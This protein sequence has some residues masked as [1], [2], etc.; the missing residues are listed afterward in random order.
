[1]DFKLGLDQSLKLGLSM[2]M[3][4]SIEILKMG[5]KELKE[6]LENES[7]KNSNIEIIFPKPSFSKNEDYENYIENVGEEDES[8][9]DYL[10]EQI[11]YLEIKKELRDILEY[12]VNNLDE[13]GYLVSNLNELRKNS[14][15]KLNLFKEAVDILYTL[16]PIG[17]GAIDL[18]DCLK[19]QLE[20]KG[21]LTRTLSN[22]L[23]KNLEDIANGDLEKIAL[24]RD[25]PLIKVKECIDTIRNLNP[26]PARG[27][28]VNKK[29]DYIV[30]DLVVEIVGEEITIN[31]NESQI[32]KI[33]LKSEN[34]RDQTF[35]LALERGIIKRQETLLEVGRYVLNHQ[36]DYLLFSKN[37]KTLKIKDVA[38]GL[39]LHEST[40]SR[41]LKDKFIRI[42]GKIEGLK[43]YIVL[44][45]KTELI[46]E[47][48][49]KIIENEDKKNPLS[50]EKILEKLAEKNLLV[51]RRT[52]GKYREELGI[53]SSRKRKK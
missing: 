17:V 42:D 12:L 14:G 30:P 1:M 23:E 36:R 48:I 13:R 2:E 43:K 32:P 45:D 21:I 39:N 18:I 22:I 33:K 20:N 5:L 3:K 46:K 24:E 26:K 49:L 6:F 53:L 28:Y 52:I 4:I 38:Y 50:D 35:A 25:I 8:L 16:E 9:I 34:K 19:I 10:E 7:I 37:L 47:E 27:F 51:Q 40:I 29:T 44:D 41:A 11:G 15:F 31:L